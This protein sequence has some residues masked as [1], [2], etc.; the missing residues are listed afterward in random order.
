M[1]E[2]RLLDEIA[3]LIAIP[4]VSSTVVERDMP[5]RPI[6]EHLA[7]R[8]ESG[9]Y[10]VQIHD[11]DCDR[12]KANLVATVGRGEGGLVVAGHTDTVPCDPELWDSDPFVMSQRGDR[13]YGLGTCDMK[14]FFAL[15]LVAA[16][17]FT[18][19][20]LRRPLTVV[21]TADEETSMAGARALAAAGVALAG[22][23]VIGE[24]TGLRPVRAH[25][26]ILMERIR[27]Q[28]RGGHSSDPR[29]GANAIEG[30]QRVLASLLA[31]RTELQQ[32][33]RDP[34]FDVPFPTLNQGRICGGDNPNRICGACEVDLDLRL[35]PGMAL[36]SF[37]R[38]LRERAAAA[39]AGS[40]CELDCQPLFAGV[41]PLDT[42]A[43]A[44]I[45][46]AAEVLTG[47]SAQAVAF[48]TEGPFFRQLGA[49]VLVLG[50]GSV[51]QAHQPNEYLELARLQP[52]LDLL[53]QLIRRFCCE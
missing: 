47:A 20:E 29:L 19:R 26:G 12:G 10:R 39:L 7:G 33:H 6:I 3:A 11:V 42:P 36:D 40:G 50:P 27:V 2:G 49:D 35:L 18:A 25:K 5:N 45:V 22:Q 43:H 38:Q 44:S 34:G 32:L 30:M 9:G 51:A 17:E 8:L 28:G 46:R 16:S 37:R 41:E 13:I 53:R 24:P 48:A 23:A 21:A 14:S 4:S 1:R 31:W 52:M 15:V